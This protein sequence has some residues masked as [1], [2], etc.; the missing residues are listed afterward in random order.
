MPAHDTFALCGLPLLPRD[1][2]ALTNHGRPG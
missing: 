2:V 1:E